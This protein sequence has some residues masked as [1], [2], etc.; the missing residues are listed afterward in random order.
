MK[1]RGQTWFD[2]WLLVSMG[3]TNLS[4]CQVEL[5][6]ST[7]IFERIFLTNFPLSSLLYIVWLERVRIR[8]SWKTCWWGIVL[9]V[10]CSPLVSFSPL[11][12]I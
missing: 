1:E 7:R 3:L 4:G 11:R 10:H 2:E 8:I 9:I 6:A 5:K 12:I